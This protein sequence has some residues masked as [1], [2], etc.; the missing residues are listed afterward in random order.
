MKDWRGNKEVYYLKTKCRGILQTEVFLG[1]VDVR[2]PKRI[3]AWCGAKARQ[4]KNHKNLWKCRD[5]RCRTLSS[6]MD[7]EEWY[8]TQLHD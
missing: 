5:E 4:T 6:M 2:V 7:V 3:C 8:N 1:A